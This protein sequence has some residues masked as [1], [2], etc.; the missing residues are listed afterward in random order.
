M[1]NPF[2]LIDQR[3]SKI[4]KL[5]IR[6]S[7][8]LIKPVPLVEE[9]DRPKDV[10]EAAD[11]LKLSVNTLYGLTSKNKITFTKAGKKLLFFKADLDNY[12]NAGRNRS[13]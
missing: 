9:E 3:L 8:H 6:L 1:D 7:D 10:K 5:L 11:F 2:E 4:E 12:L 13:R